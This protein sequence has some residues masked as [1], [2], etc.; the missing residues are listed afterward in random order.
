M[1]DIPGLM[2]ANLLFSM[3]VAPGVLIVVSVI[4]G[5]VL[6]T[7]QKREFEDWTRNW[8]LTLLSW[9]FLPGTMV[10]V[11]LR[12]GI[13]KLFRI[14]VENVGLSTT[15]AELN[16]FLKVE[17]PPRYRYR[18]RIECLGI[19]HRTQVDTFLL[20]SGRNHWLF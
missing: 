1:I 14:D 18:M 11:A 8:L 10:Y 6:L 2:M 5:L 16:L 15:Y 13:S 3:Q 19:C 17:K 9:V 12:W 7:G 4:R 20:F